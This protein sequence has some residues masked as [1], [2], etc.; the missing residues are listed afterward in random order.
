MKASSLRLLFNLYPPYLFTGIKVARIAPDYRQVRVE[1]PLRFYNRN[2]WNN[3]TALTKAA[4]E[5]PAK[6]SSRPCGLVHRFP[7]PASAGSLPS[8]GSIRI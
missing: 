7:S 1:M 3:Q 6:A 4:P 5:H 8:S 2:F